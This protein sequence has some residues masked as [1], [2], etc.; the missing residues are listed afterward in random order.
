M[1]AFCFWS[2]L[3]FV[4]QGGRSTLNHTKMWQKQAHRGVTASVTALERTQNQ[5]NLPFLPLGSRLLIYEHCQRPQINQNCCFVRWSFKHQSL[6]HLV[7]SLGISVIVLWCTCLHT[8]WI[9]SGNFTFNLQKG[10]KKQYRNL[11]LKLKIL[12]GCWT[13]VRIFPRTSQKDMC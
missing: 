12:A 7:H 11:K 6:S 13:E 5:L 3:H 1:S 8:V 2:S 9:L 4:V 10:H